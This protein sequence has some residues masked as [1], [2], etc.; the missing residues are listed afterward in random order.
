MALMLLSFNLLQS[1]AMNK[2]AT[3]KSLSASTDVGGND[4]RASQSLEVLLVLSFVDSKTA[5]S[6]AKNVG[7][8]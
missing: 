8:V 2:R 6:F 4:L 5:C 7:F 3:E 1:L